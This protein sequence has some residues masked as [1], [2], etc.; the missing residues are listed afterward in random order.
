MALQ[1]SHPE[2]ASEQAYVDHAYEC[3]DRMHADV[4]R[5]GSHGRNDYELAVF[6]NWKRARMA[7]LSDQVSA[8]V[9]GRLD[10]TDDQTFYIGRHHIRD[11][12]YETVVVDWRAPVAKA[13]Y[14]ANPADPM[15]LQR[16][17]Q[18]LQDGRTLLGISD[19]FFDASS[20]GGSGI[21]GV[22]VLRRELQRQRAGEMRDIVAT[23]QAEQ[24]LIIRSPLEGVVVVQGGPGTGKTAIGLH[25]ASFLL[26]EHRE[27]LQRQ[28]VLVVGPNP[29]F[30]RYI[31]KVLPSLGETAVVQRTIDELLVP[32][33]PIASRDPLPVA[34]LKGDPRMVEVIARALAAR[35][36]PMEEDITIRV[37]GATMTLTLAAVEA[38]VARIRAIDAPYKT[39]RATLRDALLLSLYQQYQS[40]LRVGSMAQDFE[41]VARDIR[42]DPGFTTA[43]TAVWPAVGVT[44]LISDLLR[45]PT[46]LARAAEGIL[47]RD[48]QNLLIRRGAGKV[49]D[50]PWSA[51]DRPLLDEAYALIEGLPDRHGH[52]VVDEAQDL[53]PMQ[54]R[55]LSRRALDGSMTILGDLGQA[56]GAWAHDDWAEVLERLDTPAGARVEELTLGYRVSPAIME[57]AAS[58][59]RE[60]MPTL[61]APD[62]VRAERGD[63]HVAPCDTDAFAPSVARLASALRARVG[64]AAVIS[65]DETY[66]EIAAA[67]RGAG[68]TFGEASREGL[69]EDLT[70]VRASW[71]KGLEFDGVLV[72]EPAAIVNEGGLRLL[73]IAMT[74]ALRSL[75]VAHATPLPSPLAEGLARAAA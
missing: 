6:A 7:A 10:Q 48:E 75:V 45:S 23:I 22:E 21:R 8:L 63:V 28:K 62:S 73:Y 66:D 18:Y 9:F 60:A 13:F 50:H 38:E 11:E 51:A 56:T 72:A 16:R 44:T 54:M 41:A 57:V 37:Q 25:R 47:S 59:L 67:M 49:A 55:M 14:R 36:R 1:Q 68:L 58:I 5:F 69:T 61:R 4:A 65:A 29:A 15:S 39:G 74:R 46:K 26:Y 34:R 3:M 27:T 17:R 24:D 52:V 53:S 40:K 32:L 70:L 33:V 30:M 20:M 31:E 19:D 42:T 43:L 35:A 2:L 64:F 12:A 71:A